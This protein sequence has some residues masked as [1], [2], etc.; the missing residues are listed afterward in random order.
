MYT[1]MCK[2][3]CVGVYESLSKWEYMSMWFIYLCVGIYEKNNL[4]YVIMGEVNSWGLN[5]K[6]S[7]A[8]SR[9]FESLTLDV[10]PQGFGNTI[11][12]WELAQASKALHSYVRVKSRE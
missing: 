12:D 1:C 2:D 7:I 11:E 6:S 10:N 8:S 5:L 3:V 4:I 9:A